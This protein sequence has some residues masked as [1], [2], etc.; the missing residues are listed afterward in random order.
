M[1]GHPKKLSVKQSKVWALKSVPCGSWTTIEG[2]EFLDSGCVVVV[3]GTVMCLFE[4]D[5]VL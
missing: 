1:S 2:K 4:V 5:D 3:L